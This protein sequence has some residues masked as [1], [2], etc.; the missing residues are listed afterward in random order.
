MS[1]FHPSP[2]IKVNGQLAFQLTT[3]QQACKRLFM[4]FVTAFSYQL[5][6]LCSSTWVSHSSPFLCVSY[7][8]S[9]A[10]REQRC[11]N[12]T[13]FQIRLSP[14]LLNRGRKRILSQNKRWGAS[15]F[16]CAV[17]QSLHSWL[18]KWHLIW[19]C[20]WS[21]RYPECFQDIYC[22]CRATLARYEGGEIWWAVT[23]HRARKHTHTGIRRRT[24]A[25]WR[26]VENILK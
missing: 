22:G 7:V 26:M 21:L 25:H 4:L 15:P 13:N 3:G 9:Q 5:P 17:K 18:S 6:D 24:Q 1:V 8:C 12:L 11:R 10:W 19:F 20:C 2:F 23:P 14:C 16:P